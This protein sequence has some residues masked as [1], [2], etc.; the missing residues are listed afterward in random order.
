MPTWNKPQ[1]LNSR[2][3][4]RCNSTR[5]TDHAKNTNK[6]NP[7]SITPGG[8]RQSNTREQ[9]I[10]AHQIIIQL[11]VLTSLKVLS[12]RRYKVSILE[13]E[14]GENLTSIRPSVRFLIF[15][16]SGWD[17]GMSFRVTPLIRSLWTTR[18]ISFIILTIRAYGPPCQI[19]PNARGKNST[20]VW[21]LRSSSVL[22]CASFRSSVFSTFDETIL[23]L[24]F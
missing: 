22:L 18:F 8:P 3:K 2:R 24:T 16:G 10:N 23:I 6:I 14:I 19:L 13:G 15:M 20:S 11:P 1:T 17:Q 21:C 9:T 7:L 12:L 4:W 5:D